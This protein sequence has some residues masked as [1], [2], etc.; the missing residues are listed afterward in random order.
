MAEAQADRLDELVVIELGDQSPPPTLGA[1][2]LAMSVE[3]T[4]KAALNEVTVNVDL[5]TPGF[6]VLTDSFYPGWQALVDGQESPLYRANSV[7]RAVYVPA[8]AH[9]VE[10]L[11]RPTDFYAGAAVSGTAWMVCLVILAGIGV[12]R[13]RA[14]DSR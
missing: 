1:V 8:G 4:S 3:A 10:F 13:R 12:R 5:P 2:G 6:L 7:V 9:L 14:V 11:Y